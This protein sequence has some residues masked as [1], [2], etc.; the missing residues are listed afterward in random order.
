MQTTMS[1][2]YVTINGGE[3]LLPQKKIIYPFTTSLVF[4]LKDSLNGISTTT[5]STG[6][7]GVS[8]YCAG[9]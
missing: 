3:F 2:A 9:K 7:P 5:A 1:N 8:E 4:A 6:V